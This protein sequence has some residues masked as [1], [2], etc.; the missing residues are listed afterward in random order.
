MGCMA[1]HA[2]WTPLLGFP[3]S[4][5]RGWNGDRVTR[6]ETGPVSEE[7]FCTAGNLQDES[8]NTP[9]CVLLIPFEKREERPRGRLGESSVLSPLSQTQGQGR[10][11]LGSKGWG[12]LSWFQWQA[13][14]GQ[15]LGGGP[16]PG[17]RRIALL[18]PQ[19]WGRGEHQ[20]KEDSS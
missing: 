8:I 19:T 10:S 13:A 2:L 17:A 20:F 18:S 9:D 3:G 6:A 5:S 16:S 7:S 11:L 12:Y 15:S 14:P 4:L 1:E